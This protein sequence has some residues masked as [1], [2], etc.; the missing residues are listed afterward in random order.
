MLPRGAKKSQ[1][2]SSN[3][4][5]KGKTV[6][7]ERKVGECYQWKANGQCSR[8]DSCS[9]SHGYCRGQQAQ[10]SSPAPKT[11]TQIDGRTPS[12]RSPQGRGVLLEREPGKR[13]KNSSEE[14]VRNCHVIV[15]ILPYVKITKHN[16]DAN[17][18]KNAYSGTKRLMGSPGKS[19]GSGSVA[20]KTIG[21]RVPR[22]R[23]T[24]R[25]LFH[26][27]A[28]SWDQIAPSHSPRACGTT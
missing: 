14:N 3:Q 16:R 2:E 7:V 9:F 1:S 5:S 27:R 10:S 12:T 26:G 21:L 22:C 18:V 23:A 20:F 11:Q 28:D 19:C 6:S 25:S 15:G 8:R 13:A 4:E 17:S 24:F